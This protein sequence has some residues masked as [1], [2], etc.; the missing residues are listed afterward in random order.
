MKRWITILLCMAVMMGAVSMTAFA[1]EEISVKINTFDVALGNAKAYQCCGSV[2]LPLRKICTELG[3]TVTWVEE[4]KHII[5]EDG[6][7][8]TVAKPGERVVYKNSEQLVLKVRITN[9]DGITYA[10]FEYFTEAL[11][12][13]AKFEGSVVDFTTDAFVISAET[14]KLIDN[15]TAE[16]KG[17]DEAK[18]GEILEPEDNGIYVNAGDFGL[19][20]DAKPEVNRKAIQDAIDK[21]KQIGACKVTLPQGEYFIGDDKYTDQLTVKGM[22]NL[23]IDGN[24]SYLVYVDHKTAKSGAYIRVEDSERIKLKNIHFDWDWD[25]LPLFQLGSITAINKDAGIIEVTMETVVPD[26]ANM[27]FSAV[28]AWERNNKS[29]SSEVYQW[30]SATTATIAKTGSNKIELTYGN[31]KNLD[32][33]LIG[34]KAMFRWK[35]VYNGNGID[36]GNVKN[37]TL[38]GVQIHGTAHQAT[39]TYGV[40]NYRI[41]NSG[42][43]PRKDKD[44]RCIIACYGGMETHNIY[45]NL[46]VENNVFSGVYD[47]IMHLSNAHFPHCPKI[48]ERTVYL[49]AITHYGSVAVIY[50]GAE[51]RLMS[52]EYE[53]LE[54]TSTV[55]SFEWEMNVYQTGNAHRCKVVFKDPLPEDYPEGAMMISTDQ[56]KT[57][58][59]IRNNVYENSACHGLYGVLSNSTVENNI[60]RNTGYPP[61]SVVMLN[62]WAKWFINCT[63]NNVILRNNHIED[64]DFALRDAGSVFIAGGTDSQPTNY[65]P[66]KG[67]PVTN[68]WFDKNVVKNSEWSALAV[69]SVD[70]IVITNNKFLNS[71]LAPSKDRFTGYGNVF[72]LETDNAIFAANTIENNGNEYENG[73]FYD[74]TTCTNIVIA[75][76]RNE[77]EVRKKSDSSKNV[78]Q[79]FNEDGDLVVDVGNY[80]YNELAGNWSYSTQ[81]TGYDGKPTRQSSSPGATV[82]WQPLLEEGKYKVY[83]YKVVYAGSADYNAQISVVHKNG[84][85]KTNLNYEEG[86]SGFVELGEFEFS[87]GTNGYVENKKNTE[88]SIRTSAVKFEKVR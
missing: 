50:E 45:G 36:L 58:C 71:N 14:Q 27:A 87:A 32:G 55:E 51:F 70:N 25:S 80:G 21:A 20:E 38:D 86:K 43:S 29:L 28:Q 13:D 10:P 59:I 24:G 26:M 23:E 6:E 77:F 74:D 34:N 1:G 3:M 19:S 35:P 42:I 63:I 5:V 49:D 66:V 73:L 22:S 88:M 78:I 15:A 61:L 72:F 84:T 64:C 65:Y 52:A 40:T 57:N 41:I 8:V 33:A 62:R 48:D 2:M 76:N 60:I 67:R 85:Y 11:D 4:Q 82:R 37:M 30:P 54:W 31:I 79:T 69:G 46:H 56:T 81:R 47:D 39:G 16:I 9:K 7:L 44:N 83:I 18:L 68:I 75:E 12:L 53:S 17:G